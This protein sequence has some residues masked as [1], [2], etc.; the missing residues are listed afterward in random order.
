MESRA[1]ARQ[2]ERQTDRDERGEVYIVAY[3]RLQA[4][5]HF[6]QSSSLLLTVRTVAAGQG[7][8]L[9]VEVV[10]LAHGGVVVGSTAA[11]VSATLLLHD[12]HDSSAWQ[13]RAVM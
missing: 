13:H 8:V 3:C 11:T 6:Q 9:L 2:R 7:R 4:T 5:G 12:C 10:L 1:S